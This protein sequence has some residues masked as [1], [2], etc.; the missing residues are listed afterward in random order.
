MQTFECAET[1]Q[2]TLFYP[3]EHTN[4]TATESFLAP[5]VWAPAKGTVFFGGMPILY[6]LGRG[7]V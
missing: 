4:N 1:N 3:H 2:Q 5:S 6:F 7:F